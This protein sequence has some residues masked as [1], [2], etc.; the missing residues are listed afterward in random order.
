MDINGENVIKL[1]NFSG[2]D[3]PSGTVFTSDGK[4][5]IF[6]VACG[7][8]VPSWGY[9][10]SKNF[11]LSI[12]NIQDKKLKVL[13]N[14]DGDNPAISS[15]GRF[16]SYT[17]FGDDGSESK[18]YDLLTGKEVVMPYSGIMDIKWSK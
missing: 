7:G 16:V 1:T 3:I 2:C 10:D 17:Q 4:Q 8:G 18:I 14:A 13:D 5:I 12:V 11:G 6:T 9:S 15:D